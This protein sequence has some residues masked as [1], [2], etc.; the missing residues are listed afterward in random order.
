MALMSQKEY[1]AKKGVTPQ[2]INKLVNQGKILKVGRQIDS[3]QADAAIKAYSRP[4]RV[5]KGA[6][7]KA[8]KQAG[9][10]GKKP[11][12]SPRVRVIA[13]NPRGESATASL[14][15]YR[16]MRE[17]AQAERA[18]LEL[19]ALLKQLLPANEVREAERQKNANIRTSFRRLARSLAPLLNRASSPAEV[20]Q[21]LLGEID[22][23]LSELARDPLG[24]QEAVPEVQVEIIPPPV[25][26]AEIRA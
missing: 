14:T 12:A 4:G 18:E 24:V 10:H 5:V 15:R 22:L 9:R 23:V 20:E 6:K 25:Q 21:I 19:K 16:A 26:P 17:K 2:Y 3:R 8:K 11:Q 1:A 13:A 7:S